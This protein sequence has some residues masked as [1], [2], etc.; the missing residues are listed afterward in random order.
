LIAALLLFG[1]NEY[2]VTAVVCA[3]T[4]PKVVEPITKVT[5]SP[6]RQVYS[7]F[8]LVVPEVPDEQVYVKPCTGES[9]NLP[10]TF[11]EV[12]GAIDTVLPPPL[13]HPLNKSRIKKI[14]KIKDFKKSPFFLRFGT[15]T[16]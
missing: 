9:I 14:D 8:A 16:C 7:P 2:G 6:R 3:E 15:I 1:N 13:P 4:V 12:L 5:L 11:D 10:V